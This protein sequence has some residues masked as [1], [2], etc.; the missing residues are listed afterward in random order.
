MAELST[1]EWLDTLCPELA[2]SPNVDTYIL[3][4]KKVLNEMVWGVDYA[5]AVAL[6]ASHDFT[7][8]QRA[9][10][11]TGLLTSKTEGKLSVSYWN[12]VNDK[13]KKT[14]YLTRYGRALL[15]LMNTK[16]LRFSIGVPDVL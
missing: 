9:G 16:G 13:T 14:L 2:L 15:E 11:E 7:M 5:Y 8:A 10:D 6:R 1:E 4:A 12:S 3:M